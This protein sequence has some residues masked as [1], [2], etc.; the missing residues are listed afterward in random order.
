MHNEMIDNQPSTEFNGEDDAIISE[1]IRVLDT[2]YQSNKRYEAY[3]IILYHTLNNSYAQV[4]RYL[5][6]PPTT[7]RKIYLRGI[8]ILKKQI[9][10]NNINS[11]NQWDIHSSIAAQSSLSVVSQ[12]FKTRYFEQSV[13]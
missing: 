1:L 6:M 12:L 4:G 2:M 11:F 9:N 8:K 3:V 5:N 7:V 13:K 10:G